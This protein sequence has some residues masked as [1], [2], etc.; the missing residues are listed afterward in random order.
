MQKNESLL[1]IARKVVDLREQLN[2]ITEL[3]EKA[4]LPCTPN[5]YYE[6]SNLHDYLVLWSKLATWTSYTPRQRYGTLHIS[7]Y[8]DLAARFN[9]LERAIINRDEFCSY[10]VVVAACESVEKYIEELTKEI[11]R[12]EKQLDTLYNQFAKSAG[13]LSFIF[14]ETKVK[15]IIIN[16]ILFS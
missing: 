8:N 1:E 11:S 10:P 15:N 2:T 5:A 4:F 14:K 6:L 13:D 12:Q 9:L 16:K 7:H 3:K